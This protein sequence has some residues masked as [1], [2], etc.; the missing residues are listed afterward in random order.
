MNNF[1]EIIDEIKNAND[2][3]ISSHVNPDGDAI[4]GGLSLLLAVKKLKDKNGD[5]SNK[6]IRF[7]LEES[8]PK[9]LKF[10]KHSSLVEIYDP[11]ETY[12]HDLFIAVDCATKERMG[13][14][15]DIIDPK[16]KVINIDHHTSNSLFGNLNYV[17]EISSTS[18]IMYNLIEKLDV[19]IDIDMAE[20]I[21]TGIVNDT[22]NF[23]HDNVSADTFKI[24]SK[25]KCIGVNTS[26]VVREFFQT[27]SMPTLKLM[28][29]TLNGFQFVDEKKLAYFFLTQEAL[30][31]V[32]GSKE[33]TEGLVEVLRSYEATEVA[34][35]L[36]EEADGRIK[37]SLRSKSADVNKIAS[38]FGGGGHVKAAG[39]NTAMK[40]DEVI[41]QV[42]KN[43]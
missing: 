38:I 20:T 23:A 16:A 32:G 12:E 3:I 14:V 27:K 8:V 2:I 9:N 33:E 39:F 22:G 35:F 43:L 11:V 10:L 30:K 36:R 26:K 13:K 40:I 1:T 41:K 31:S 21:Y 19:H 4:G 25:L 17:Q 42:V 15:N 28:G 7:V 18:E 6:N 29:L 5:L 37:G 24:A 34:L